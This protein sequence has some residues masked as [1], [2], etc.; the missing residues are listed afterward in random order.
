MIDNGSR[1]ETATFV[2]SFR[3]SGKIATTASLFGIF[4]FVI[5][6]LAVR[7]TAQTQTTIQLQP[8][9]SGLSQPVL[10]THARDG[11]NRL[12]IVEQTGL[13]KVLQPGSTT[14]TTFLDLTSKRVFG[15]E[16]GVLGLAFHPEYET[17]RRFFVNYT[18][19]GDGATVIA[20]YLAS[21]VESERRFDDRK[22]HSD[23]CSTLLKPQ[24]R[25]D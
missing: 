13:I 21:P 17:N 11:S 18:R 22:D 15:G 16:Q 14:P 4:A 8:F 1:V 25:N 3:P 19:T 7:S 5:A 23:R 2:K 12:F 9:L 24:W 6:C 10:I 20:E